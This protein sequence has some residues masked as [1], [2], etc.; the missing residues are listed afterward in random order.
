M[1]ICVESFV[2]LQKITSCALQLGYCFRF[3]NI[4]LHEHKE[5]YS[6]DGDEII[7]NTKINTC[8]VKFGIVLF[9]F[10]IYV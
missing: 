7:D 6:C 8:G 10:I 9:L 5:N 3:H 4:Q 1:K 2:V